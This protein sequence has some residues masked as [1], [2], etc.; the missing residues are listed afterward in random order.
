[1]KININVYKFYKIKRVV[2]TPLLVDY[3]S[4]R[5]FI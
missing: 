4:I 2:F 3:T 5:L 1:M